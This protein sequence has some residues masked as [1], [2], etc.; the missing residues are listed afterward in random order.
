[1]RPGPSSRAHTRERRF[2]VLEQLVER[3]LELVYIER[4]RYKCGIELV[5]QLACSGGAGHHQHGRRDAALAEHSNQRD[6]AQDWKLEIDDERVEFLTTE[7]LQRTRAVRGNANCVVGSKTLGQHCANVRIIL[8]D[9]YP[10]PRIH[11]I[12]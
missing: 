12:P 7:Q 11:E 5:S 8:Y 4:L 1:V 10:A 2:S 6:P 9:E 3:H